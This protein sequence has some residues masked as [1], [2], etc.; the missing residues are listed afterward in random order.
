MCNAFGDVVD[1]LTGQLLAG[2]R[3]APDTMTLADTAK[4]LRDGVTPRRVEG[5]NTTLAVVATN[6]HLSKPQAQN[7]RNW[8]N[9]DAY[10][11]FL[12]PIPSSMVT[13]SSLCRLAQ[14]TLTSAS[15][16]MRDCCRAARHLPGTSRA[17]GRSL[18]G[19]PG[20]GDSA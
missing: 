15:A 13:L 17:G 11:V 18:G 6:A 1:P 16:P 7:W 2:T 3:Q 8:R 9:T 10:A 4:L 20:L 19:V 5:T 14:Q 12:R